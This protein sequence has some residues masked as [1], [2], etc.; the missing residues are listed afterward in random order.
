MVIKDG[1]GLTAFASGW[2]NGSG[3]QG[4]GYFSSV[5]SNSGPGNGGSATG[6]AYPS[7]TDGCPSGGYSVGRSYA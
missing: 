7:F 4:M 3:L 6:F 1:V 5:T 2:A